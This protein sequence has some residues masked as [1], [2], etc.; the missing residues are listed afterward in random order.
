MIRPLLANPL[1]QSLTI[2]LLIALTV[3]A[4]AM[5]LRPVLVPCIASFVLYSILI[6]ATNRLEGR[7]IS[8]LNAI[9]VA[10]SLVVALI[11]LCIILIFPLILDQI[12]Q[13]HRQLPFIWAQ[14]SNA[15]H[16]AD[17]WLHNGINLS[18]NGLLM[19]N[20]L[21]KIQ[22]WGASAVVA[23]A[24][25]IIQLGVTILL[26]PI[27]TFFILR[28]FRTIRNRALSWLP[29]SSFELGCL[30][31]HQVAQRLQRY[32]RAVLVQSGIM[33]MVSGMGFFLIGMDMAVLFGCL[34][35]IFNLIP[36]IGPFLAVIP[37]IILTISSGGL[38]TWLLSGIVGVILIAETI[39]NFIVIPTVI[40]H[41]VDLHPLL[42]L[43]GI[44]VFGYLFGFIGLLVAIPLLTTSKI[45]LTGLLH[46]LHRKDLYL[47]SRLTTHY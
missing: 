21:G 18:I 46:G 41:S 28:D 32:I 43:L 11:M 2:F 26:V 8:H 29:N 42:V 24:G 7:G 19:D 14:L 31:Y 47:D 9:A 39:D 35:G 37:P 23:S 12:E 33:A 36:Y 16:Q 3:S 25:M 44:I 17:T 20:W 1:G 13:L 6:A 30:I 27:I 10:L 34:A 15:G 45:I 22:D 4:G 38:D 5:L 40:A